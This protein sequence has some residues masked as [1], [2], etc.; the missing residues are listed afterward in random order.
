A[1][2]EPARVPG[3]AKNTALNA[4][5]APSASAR[6]TV[7]L[8]DPMKDYLSRI[9]RTALLTAEQ[10]VD[11]AKRIEAGLFARERLERLG[12]ELSLQD[13]ADLEWIAADGVR[14]K[15]HMVEANL[16]LVVSLA[17][18][19]KIGRA[20]CRGRESQSVVAVRRI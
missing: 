15:E 2:P 5:R 10:E 16:R 14:A 20:S 7:N 19:Y 17:K 4:S 3:R 8:T 18:R 6:G 9:G 13:R 1:G 11:L 12:D